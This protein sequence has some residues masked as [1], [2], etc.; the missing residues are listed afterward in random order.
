[1]RN[2]FRL[3][4]AVLLT[5]ASLAATACGGDKNAGTST[6]PAAP[7]ATTPAPTAGAPAPV[8]ATPT[9]A[10][11]A[12]ATAAATPEHHSK[13]GGAV[14]GGV[15][16]HM[17]GGKKGALLGAAAGAYVQHRRNKAAAAAAGQ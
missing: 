1:M 15:A 16:G 11:T 3:H 4:A 6:V 10:A 7:V 14:V 5:S 8:T 17:I 12:P 2:R 13:L 9:G